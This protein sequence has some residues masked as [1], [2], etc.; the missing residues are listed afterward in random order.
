[1]TEMLNLEHHLCQV[2]NKIEIEISTK[3]IMKC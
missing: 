3:N 2:K 1:M